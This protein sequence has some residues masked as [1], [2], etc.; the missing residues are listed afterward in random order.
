MQRYQ[1]QQTQSTLV[2]SEAAALYQG[3]ENSLSTR[4]IARE[5]GNTYVSHFVDMSE[6]VNFTFAQSELG[7]RT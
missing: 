3:T 4:A 2:T 7:S 1:T 5:E 6:T